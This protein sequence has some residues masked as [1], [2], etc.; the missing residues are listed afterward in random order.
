M[1][2]KF[3]G[4]LFLLLL[5]A[6]LGATFTWLQYQKRQAKKAAAQ[7]LVED[8]EEK[9]LVLLAF[10]KAE[11]AHRLRWEHAREF[12]YRGQ[13]FDVVET[14]YRGDSVY[15]R[16]WW[17]HAETEL[18]REL[19]TLQAALLG[20]DPQSQEN[21]ERLFQFYKSLICAEQPR[22]YPLPEI[23]GSILPAYRF[24]APLFCPNPPVPPPRQ[25]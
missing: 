19:A 3:A 22:V 21:Q 12:E 25:S 7:I 20:Q 5:V 17:D 24:G 1:Q 23:A 15:F 18:N 16:C 10:S 8:A 11:A 4:I 2:G 14:E 9:E 13:M 6:P